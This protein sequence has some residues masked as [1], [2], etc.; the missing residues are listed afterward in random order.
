MSGSPATSAAGKCGVE[1]QVGRAGAGSH[2]AF[3]PKYVREK[4]RKSI[5]RQDTW[6]IKWPTMQHSM[7]I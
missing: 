7:R 3:K 4:Y 1:D 2:L 6:R 5:S